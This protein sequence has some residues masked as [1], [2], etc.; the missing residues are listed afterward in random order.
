MKQGSA[1]RVTVGLLVAWSAAIVGVASLPTPAGATDPVDRF[2]FTPVADTYVSDAEPNTNFGS[3]GYWWV[4]AS[5]V[6]QA[7]VQFDLSNITGRNVEDVTLRLYQTNSSPVGGRVFS[8]T[9]TSW[10]ESITWSTRP[11][12]DGPQV[13]SFGAV[14]TGVWYEADLGQLALSDGLISL[15]M[16][17]TN[18]D[19]AQWSSRESLQPPQ[20]I[21]E[22]EASPGLVLD[23][24]SQVANPYLGSSDP[25]YYPSNHHL[26]LTSAGRLLLV[27]GRHKTG[28]QLAW[29]DPGGGWQTTTTGDVTNGLLE[30]SPGSTGDWPASV[31][32]ASDS[33]GT[34]HAWVVWSGFSFAKARPVHLRRLS[35]LDSPDGPTV[36]PLVTIQAAGLGNARVD[37]SFED[38]LDGSQRG[39]VSYFRRKLTSTY[40]FV[41]AWLTDL[42][43]DTPILHDEAILSSGTDSNLT[44]TLTPTINGMRLVARSK[45][46]KVKLFAHDPSAP[47][48]TWVQG[49][50]GKSTWNKARPSAVGLSSGEVLAAV[51]SSSTSHDVKVIRFTSTGNTATVDLM[52]TGYS[53]PSIAS[54]GTNAWLVMVRDSDT[55]IVSRQFSPEPGWSS[56]D[57]VEVGAE[58][59]GGYTWP[60]LLRE[61]DGRLQFVF[62]GLNFPGSTTQREVLAYQRPL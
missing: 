49:S 38:A 14:S 57:E 44:G 20:L 41:A 39:V 10:D 62:G 43:T 40:E 50:A 61:T 31:A 25:T 5:P 1:C 11:T 3:A 55:Y 21:V 8:I 36:G 9:S 51:R 35:D 29:R 23:G 19:G 4:D 12:I 33:T 18:T 34:E 2:V 26:A 37:L 60:N 6:R 32:V 28:V 46:G 16:D 13:G 22:V 17:S 58:G 30:P 7:F 45:S 24:L 53:N 59:G 27:H 52:L 56:V 47:L 42:D 15:A 54:D 48:G